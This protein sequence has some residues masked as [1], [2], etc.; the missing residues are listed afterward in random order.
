MVDCATFLRTLD[1]TATRSAEPGEA[2]VSACIQWQAGVLQAAAA[3]KAG[4]L[5]FAAGALAFV[6]A[7]ASGWLAWN[8]VQ[9]QI[10]S[11]QNEQEK[12]RQHDQQLQV[13]QRR[14][15]LK[16]EVYLQAS[17]CLAVGM[18]AVTRMADL[19]MS[20]SAALAQYEN[21]LPDLF[22]AHLVARLDT[23]EKLLSAVQ[24]LADL[25]RNLMRDRPPGDEGRFTLPEVIEWGRKCSSALTEVI[26]PFTQAVG[27]MRA[28]LNLAT[29]VNAHEQLIRKTMKAT[30]DANE[31]Y[32]ADLFAAYNARF[33]SPASLD[34][35][36]RAHDG[37]AAP[38]SA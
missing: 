12:Q 27:A 11:Q 10:R 16:S 38:L 20:P 8:A 34:E 3:S 25:H 2:I 35:Q 22:A 1:V 5:T 29:D 32:Y 18:G 23:A 24:S 31:N 36:G 9:R 7:I 4:W 37:P 13:R 6:G 21:A 19:R 26:S 15:Q 14:Q 30:L 28:E 33:V 17:K